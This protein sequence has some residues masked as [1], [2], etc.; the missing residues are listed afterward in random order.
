MT[1]SQFLHSLF[2]T[3]AAYRIDYFVIGD[4][5]SLPDSVGQ[6]DLD[7]IVAPVHR[8][9]LHDL[10]AVLCRDAGVRLASF[11]RNDTSHF[12]RLLHTDWGLQLDVFHVNSL[13][14]RGA[15]YFPVSLLRR[16]LTTWHDVRVLSL[17]FSLYHG[18]IKEALHLLRAKDKYV[19]GFFQ[20][21]SAE[22]AAVLAELTELYGEKVAALLDGVAT[23]DDL[24]A[25]IPAFGKTLRR[26]VKC[27]HPFAPLF[28]RL[29]L[30]GRFFRR[31][32]G[33]VIAVLGTDGSG[34]STVINA[35]TPWLSECFHDSVHYQH[36]RP[37]LLPDL[38]VVTGKKKPQAGPVTNPHGGRPSSFPVSL[39]RWLYYM[40]DYT[41]GY[42][43]RVFPHV[44]TR[45]W[46][47]IFD[48]YYQD[49][50]IDPR[51]SRTQLPHWLFRLGEVFV[52]SPD[53]ILCLGGDP[54]AIYARKP[55]TSLDEV[56][57]QTDVLRRLCDA[58]KNAVWVDTTQ[59]LPDTLSAARDAVFTT[60]TRRFSFS[61]IRG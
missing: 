18:F 14:Y 10:L 50:Y 6:S 4:Y 49:Y 33:Y 3:L 16:H 42:L 34:K 15:P 7:I 53:V 57:R 23:R 31:R 17:D 44:R 11:Y 2:Q 55:E 48:R 51:R 39:V 27:R 26:S 60:L 25:V 40:L 52:P 19:D 12:Y 20:R 43:V 30:A 58:R 56:R 28:W 41:L 21:L 8:A 22:R 45:S 54:E 24:L 35:L 1:Q 59:P 47:Y 38:G 36:L 29:R 32:P 61:S 9:R 46:C 13:L 5:R 37:T